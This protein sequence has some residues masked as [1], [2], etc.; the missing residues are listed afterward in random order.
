ML[1]KCF[2]LVSTLIEVEKSSLYYIA[3]YVAAK[4]TLC[5]ERR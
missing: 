4:E 1:E 5:L 2:E 3:G